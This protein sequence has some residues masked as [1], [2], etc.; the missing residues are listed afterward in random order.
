MGESRT[1]SVFLQAI[2]HHLQDDS[3]LPVTLQIQGTVICGQLISEARYLREL[4]AQQKPAPEVQAALQTIDGLWRT[5]EWHVHL[6]DARYVQ[7]GTYWPPVGQPGFLW[8]GRVTAVDGFT[9]NACY[10]DPP[11]TTDET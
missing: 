3:A 6:Q 7:N 1:N 10:P 4:L 8:R 5:H 2:L 11:Q 9:L